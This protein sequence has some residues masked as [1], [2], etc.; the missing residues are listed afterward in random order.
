MAF[1]KFQNKNVRFEDRITITST[2]S[3]GFPTSFFRKNK[4]DQFKFVVLYYDPEEKS[5]GFY[6]SNDETEKYKFSI[7][8]SKQGYGGSIVA[9]SFFKT[10]N[11]DP[12]KYRGRYE[13]GKRNLPEIGEIFV[14]KL[15]EREEKR[16]IELIQETK[17]ELSN[18]QMP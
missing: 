3:F 18:G 1:Q 7:I 15:K 5:V 14:I 12:K 6:F 4:I 16:V 2:N 13:W 11:I 8:K 9:T 10:Y 17:D